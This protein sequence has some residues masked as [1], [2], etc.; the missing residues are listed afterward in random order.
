VTFLTPLFL[1]G[2][3]A[4]AIPI[5]IHL[6]RREK[7]PKIVFSTLRFIKTTTKKLV[8]F[9]QIQQWLLLL[10]RSALIILLVLAFARP[11][12]DQSIA[13][14]IDAE[15]EAAVILF[16]VSLSMQYGDNFER[17]KEAVR[18]IL[19][20]LSPGDEAAL[21]SFASTAVN[22][23]ELSTDI[24]QLRSRLDAI[25]SP[26]Y[27]TVRFFP[28]LRLANEILD[29][30]RYES[31]KIY[32]V[33][34][35]QA[36]GLSE[37]DQGWTLSPGV[38][39]TG[40]DVGESTTRNLVLTDVRSPARLI[41][42]NSDYNILARVR[43]TGSVHLPRA[44]VLLR[45]DGETVARETVE[46]T[47]RSEAVVTLPARF[48]TSGARQGEVVVS[49]DDFLVDNSFYFT[50]D[51][52]PRIR[53]LIING[54]PSPNWFDDES[55]WLNLALQG[56]G[57][58]P[59]EVQTVDVPRFDSRTLAQ[60]DIAVL[61][62][63]A[64]LDNNAVSA[65]NEYVR[66]GG[67]VLFAPG[68]NVNADQFNR[69]F[70]AVSPAILE[71]PLVLDRTT[72]DYLLIADVDRRHPALRPLELDW[73]ARFDAVWSVAA[74]SGSEV[75]MRFDNSMPALIERSVGE[76][77][78]M[79]FASALDLKWSNLPLQGLYVPFV[80]ETL[81]Y[82]VQPVLKQRAYQI[83]D[84]I[85]LSPETVARTATL[86][87]R[88]TDGTIRSLP[89]D[90]PFY[91]AQRPGILAV[92]AEGQA[93]Y[94]VNLNPAASDLARVLPTL[95]HDRIINP[96]TTPQQSVQV[97][98]AQLVAELE[99]PQRLWWWIIALVMLLLLVESYIA[100]RTYR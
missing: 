91:A 39:F 90:T 9:Q 68:D 52:L 49:G 35:F 80:H 78:T 11:L 53:V 28:A 44:E 8:L 72:N 57:N 63:V 58:S 12:F 93:Y 98:T 23:S 88:E 26:G 18:Q 37:T 51:V 66:G 65:I 45:I 46:L 25:S 86:A 34:D 85:D 55:H 94:A 40:L 15:P 27:D 59:F 73:S 82:M 54:A 20:D 33:S 77:M 89:A 47:D 21:V 79:L 100:N 6:I 1:L 41:E 92:G 16:D 76:G 4:A 70:G 24:S 36:N 62:N 14:M 42:E 71:R 50:I 84:I 87:L 22:V 32:L 19:A 81:R 97:R 17:G 30:S 60:T 74:E 69:Q 67:K 10:M 2:L 96:D 61:L 95:V 48:E 38:S 64:D 75:L 13:R 56:M 43:S 99:Q 7:P 3:L 83:G 29:S 31:R 5:A